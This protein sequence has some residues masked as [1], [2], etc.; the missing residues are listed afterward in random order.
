MRMGR[1]R[2]LPIPIFL[3]L[4]GVTN[5]VYASRGGVGLIADSKYYLGA[6]RSLLD[7]QGYVVPAAIG[8][9]LIV[10]EWPPLFSALLGGLGLFGVDPWIGARW[11]NIGLFGATILVGTVGIR[12][13]TGQSTRLAL[14]GGFL[15]ATSVDLLRVHTQAGTEPLFLFFG[16]LGLILVAAHLEQ[17]A[18]RR[19]LGAAA[20]FSLAFMSRFA[21]VVLVATGVLAIL[22]FDR[23]DR[24]ARLKDAVVLGVASSFPM[25]L[26]M[27]RNWLSARQPIGSFRVLA[28]HP[29]NREQAALGLNTIW[30]WILP[31]KDLGGGPAT[32]IGHI[33]GF[34]WVL[35]SAAVSVAVIA[36]LRWRKRAEEE[37]SSEPLLAPPL[38][39]VLLSFIVLYLGFLFVSISFLD[40]TIPLDQRLLSPIF[41]ASLI[42]TIGAGQRLLRSFR[43]VRPVQWASMLGCLLIAAVYANAA[44]R[45]VHQGHEN[46][47][48]YAGRVWRESDILRKVA[49][50]PAGTTI[51][52]NGHD[53]VTLVTGRPA[54][55]LPGKIRLNTGQRN[56][57]YH[58]DISEMGERLRR[59]AVIVYL[60]R[61]S[62]RPHYPS[63]AEL[64]QQL[65]LRL[66]EK[67]TDGSIY[68]I[69][70]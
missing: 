14:L 24:Q 55:E 10:T 39:R 48:G 37:T 27:I 34:R 44:G 64:K 62:W 52:S 50:L 45:W 2:T 32:L 11:L 1:P 33:P 15:M 53:A 36:I 18:L 42:L 40:R 49:A 19:L 70:Q 35:I 4:L 31:A 67:E 5:A 12:H 60:D 9:P 66:R 58:S 29:V 8:P 7:G 17:P 69:A 16:L 41:P 25:F 3:A 38:L 28:V 47:L 51:Y 21:G 61:I 23:R 59:G 30:G 54:D 46:G 6:A 22:F 68:D 56:P 26:W 43:R 57:N 20:A 13:V 65:P 63:E